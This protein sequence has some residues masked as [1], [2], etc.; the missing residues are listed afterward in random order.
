MALEETFNG[1]VEWRRA[2]AAPDKD[3]HLCLNHAQMG[4]PFNTMCVDDQFRGGYGNETISSTQLL[5]YAISTSHMFSFVEL[6]GESSYSLKAYADDPVVHIRLDNESILEK[7]TLKPK[8]FFEGPNVPHPQVVQEL[9]DA[10]SKRSTLEKLL[11]T[12]I[13]VRPM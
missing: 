4:A 13:E 3:F 9:H 10:A 8:T 11:N 12:T 2:E 7:V 1:R 6:C 5:L